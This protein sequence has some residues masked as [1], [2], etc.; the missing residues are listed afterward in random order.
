MTCLKP[1]R[2]DSRT[3]LSQQGFLCLG[4]LANRL[5]LSLFR[6][7]WKFKTTIFL[8]GRL[9]FR[10]T[11]VN[12]HLHDSLRWQFP[13]LSDEIPPENMGLLKSYFNY[14]MESSKMRPFYVRIECNLL[15]KTPSKI[16]ISMQG[17]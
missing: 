6:R 16:L 15:N 7:R 2:I 5:I 17:I 9:R 13:K 3:L 12:I 8:S 11:H 4:L 14:S 10:R 1:S